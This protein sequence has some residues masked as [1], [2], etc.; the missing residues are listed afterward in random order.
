MTKFASDCAKFEKRYW[1]HMD[2]IDKLKTGNA[3]ASLM[4]NADYWIEFNRKQAV[5]Y[6]NRLYKLCDVYPD[7]FDEVQK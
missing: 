4:S 6:G 7:R 3:G 1:Q 2:N 5:K